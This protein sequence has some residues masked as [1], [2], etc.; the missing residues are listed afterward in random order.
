MAKKLSA[1]FI[2]HRNGRVLVVEGSTHR[3]SLNRDEATT[4]TD[5]VTATKFIELNRLSRHAGLRV[6]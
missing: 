3:W 1:W 4:W 2:L 6:K 5:R